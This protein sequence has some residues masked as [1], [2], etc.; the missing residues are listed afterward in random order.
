MASTPLDT[1][2][3]DAPAGRRPA[4]RQATPNERMRSTPSGPTTRRSAAADAPTVGEA[5]LPERPPHALP[6]A[7]V[8]E[9]LGTEARGLSERE[10]VR[11]LG[12]Y[13]PNRPPR[14]EPESLARVLLRQLTSPLVLVLVGAGLLALVMGKL[15][16]GLVVLG[17]VVLN[18]VV[19]FVQEWRAGQAIAA[20]DA[21]VPRRVTARR[22]GT[23]AVRDAADLVPGD[24]VELAAGDQVAADL[25]LVTLRGLTI[26]ESALTGESVPVAKQLD[27]VEPD[28]PLAERTSMAYG[29]SLVTAGT[30]TGVVVATAGDTEL[31]R[32]A[33][34]LRAT[35]PAQT[36]LARQLARVGTIISLAVVAVAALIGGVAVARGWD[37]ADAVLA[38]VALAVAAIPEGLPAIVTIVLAVAVRRMARRNAVVRHLPAVETLGATTVICTDKTGTLTQNEMTV[39]ALWTPR[40]GRWAVDGVGYAPHGALRPAAE[41]G[42]HD[43]AHDGAHGAPH[44]TA[45]ATA[46]APPPA[47]DAPAPA[48]PESVHALLAAAALCNDARLL[49]PDAGDGATGERRARGWRIEGDPTDG[50]LLSLAAKGGIALDALAAARPRID[51]VPFDSARQWMAT[52]HEVRDAGGD[53]G[54]PAGARVRYVKGAPEVL[55]AP[56]R[57]DGLG[58]ALDPEAV[59][60]AVR[61]M[62]DQG[63]RVLA[64]AE[65]AEP[66]PPPGGAEPE[67]EDASLE[68]LR[69]LGLV[70]M[71]D[72]PRPEVG[73]AIA[74]CRTAGVRVVMITGDH[75]DTAFA[76]ARELGIDVSHPAIDGR[77]LAATPDAELP[78]VA[79][80]ASVFARVTPADKLRLVEALQHEGSVVAMTGDGVNDAPAL[81]RADVGVAMG[82]GGTDV[83]REASALVLTDDH[84]A[85]IVKA[86]HEGR[87]VHDTLRRALAFVLPTNLALA[88]VLLVAVLAFPVVDGAPLLPMSPVQLLWVN[89]VST[90]ALALP[91]AF[92]PPEAGTM[93]RPP[94]DPRAS[95]LGGVVLWRTLA[96]APLLALGVLV[97]F[98]WELGDARAHAA[99]GSAGAATAAAVRQAQTLGVTA[100]VLLQVVYAFACRSLLARRP[101]PAAGARRERN[102]AL[103]VGMLGILLLQAALVYWGPLARLFGTAPLSA[104]AWGF[105]AALAAAF[106]VLLVVE[107]LV[108]RAMAGGAPGAPAVGQGGP[109]RHPR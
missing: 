62:A 92:E 46:S 69:L 15:I 59:R 3:A 98:W 25:R 88:L 36:P 105:A 39:R 83:A 106:A 11:R 79:R 84:F 51:A 53:D 80:R 100:L 78:A 50:A 23:L 19:G 101:A 65:R 7:A 104:R 56:L 55:V 87:R 85:T 68:G 94:R 4:R 76:I 44:D 107:R 27:A 12:E 70:G 91:F 43:G 22:D 108:R 14:P 26:D 20:L 21:L 28:A 74:A 61:W 52:V 109:P 31:G 5:P 89:L 103:L 34:M 96:A 38:A 17:V 41:H 102:P 1:S 66:A 35:A 82:R 54:A 9:W 2:P 57:Q 93:Q 63:L 86:V 90:V 6:A 95:L 72:P 42:A 37:V 45:S 47:W 77:V 32:I 67:A 71:S 33:A 10:A 18:A 29:G 99:A 16:D 24:V 8:L 64:V 49:P 73:D 13:G 40:A 30:A 97:A 58:R 75:A 60:A 48:V 81:R